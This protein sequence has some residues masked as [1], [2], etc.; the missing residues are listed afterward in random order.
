LPA[1]ALVVGGSEL[2]RREHLRDPPIVEANLVGHLPDRESTDRVALKDPDGD[3]DGIRITCQDE[4]WRDP[5]GKATVVL[6]AGVDQ[7]RSMPWK[8]SSTISAWVVG[9]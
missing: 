6:V 8:I 4:G 3:I 5:A 7:G 1:V 2:E 9:S